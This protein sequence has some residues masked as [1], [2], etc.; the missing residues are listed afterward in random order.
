[1]ILNLST[2]KFDPTVKNKLGEFRIKLDSI[3]QCFA[4]L[5]I[6]LSQHLGRYSDTEA[7]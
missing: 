4:H 5:Q 1:M 2:V 6:T 3:P 7:I